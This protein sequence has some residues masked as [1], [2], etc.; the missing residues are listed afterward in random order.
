MQGRGLTQ[1]STCM[2]TTR[3]RHRAKQKCTQTD[4]FMIFLLALEAAKSIAAVPVAA[5][6]VAAKLAA[7]EPV[8]AAVMLEATAVRVERSLHEHA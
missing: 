7:A 2:R 1:D 5:V 4:L 6:P 8:A 3:S